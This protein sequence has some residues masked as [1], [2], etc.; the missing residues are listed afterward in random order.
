M[1]FRPQLING[2]GCNQDCEI[3]EGWVCALA[4]REEVT[5]LPGVPPVMY[6]VCTLANNQDGAEAGGDSGAGAG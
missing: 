5:P 4:E 6:S 2:D 3:E 1:F